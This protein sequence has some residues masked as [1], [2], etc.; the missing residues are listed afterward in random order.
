MNLK[1]LLLSLSLILYLPQLTL[2]DNQSDLYF[3]DAHSQIDH[4]T[5]G[6]LDIVLERMYDHNVKTTLLASRQKRSQIDVLNWHAEYPTSII[7]LIRSKSGKYKKNKPNYYPYIEKQ[8]SNNKY[9]GTSEVLIY[10][11]EKANSHGLVKAPMIEVRLN[12]KRVTPLIEASMKGNWPFIIHI[13]FASLNKTGKKRHMQD[14]K[15]LLGQYPEHPFALM[16]M[17]QLKLEEVSK[18]VSDYNN[19]YFITSHTTPLSGKGQPW[20]QIFDGYAFS[21]EWR[22]LFIRHSDKFIFALDNVWPKHWSDYHYSE[23]MNYWSSAL[24]KLPK[25]TAHAIAHGNTERLW[26]LK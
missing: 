16:H 26:N 2:A 8:I 11:A 6:G 23:N 5:R 21:E 1:T 17:G 13:E 20:T 25:A 14:L 3:I 19:L 12:D 15:S 24:N 18:L 4:K 7:P 10:H 9:Q 22:N